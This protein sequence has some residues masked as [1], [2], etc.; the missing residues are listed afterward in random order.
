M[1]DASRTWRIGGGGVTLMAGEE[2]GTWTRTRCTRVT[3][4]M[5]TKIGA[6][7]RVAS[8]M[9]EVCENCVEELLA[10]QLSTFYSLP[11]S[12]LQ[13]LA[14]CFFFK[15]YIHFYLLRTCS[16]FFYFFN[17]FFNIFFFLLIFVVCLFCKLSFG[18]DILLF[19]LFYFLFRFSLFSRLLVS[20]L[21]NMFYA[22]FTFYIYFFFL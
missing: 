18:F 2:G 8:C 22:F 19:S 14:F 4:R 21:S 15:K 17:F 16:C 1:R 11:F 10:F 3:P 7:G 6:C 12:I 9:S 20:L 5:K 13:R